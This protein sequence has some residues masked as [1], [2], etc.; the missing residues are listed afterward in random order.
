[1]AG[2]SAYAAIGLQGVVCRILYPRKR[3]AY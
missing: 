2:H 1:M 3:G